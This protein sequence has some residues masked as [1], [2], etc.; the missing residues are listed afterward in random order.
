[1]LTP[2]DIRDKQFVKAVFGGYDMA[3][4]D[5]FLDELANDY[6]A[7]VKENAILKS[8]IKVLVEKVEEY[9]ATEDA[10]RMALLTAQKMGD[11]LVTEAQQKKKSLLAGVEEELGSRRKELAE[12]TAAEESKL[13][14]LKAATANCVLETKRAMLTLATVLESME[15][16]RA[17]ETREATP[18]SKTETPAKSEPEVD[19]EAVMASVENEGPA[20]AQE[21]AQE[22]PEAAPESGEEEKTPRP[23]FNFDNLQFGKNFN[24]D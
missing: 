18:E 1:M 16:K 21:K 22:T 14:Q 8:K 7:I 4:V 10:M 2:Q 12:K 9:R 20:P 3:G 15:E 11:E 13:A 19:V 24:H 6:A 5:D 23:A 17:P